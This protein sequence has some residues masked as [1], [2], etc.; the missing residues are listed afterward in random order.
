M[1]VPHPRG[2]PGHLLPGLAPGLEL[3]H[4]PPLNEPVSFGSAGQ[5]LQPLS[6][7][8]WS[9]DASEA[10]LLGSYEGVRGV[11]R[12]TIAPGVG[13]RVPELVEQTEAA[14]VDATVTSDGDLFL[15]LDGRLWF[16]HADRIAPITLP[17]GAPAPAGPLLWVPPGGAA[18]GL[19]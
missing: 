2:R 9:W 19:A 7:L 6:F 3:Y 8:T 16:D 17:A 13:L 5:Q 14:S 10:Y 12:I 11:Y 18:S 1:P 15:L 4:R